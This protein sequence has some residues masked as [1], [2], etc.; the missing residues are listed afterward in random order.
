[1]IHDVI[2]IGAGPAGLTA[3]LYVLRANLKALIIEDPFIA[4]QAAYAFVIENFPGFPGG[5]SGMDLM[6]KLKEQ[7]ASFG[8]E[9]LS[10]SAAGITNSG[11]GPQL[12]QVSAG[13][14]VYGAVSVIVASGAIPKKLG[15][16]GEYEFTGKGVSYCA[17]CDGALFKDK[18]VVVAG[19]G[20]SALEE[21][22]FLSRFAKKVSIV[23][24]RDKLRAAKI[25][26]TKV[27]AQDKIGIMWNS[28]I[29]E[30]MGEKAVSK[31]RLRDTVTGELRD[32]DC[33]G[34]FVSVGTTPNTDFVKDTLDMDENGYII[35][36]NGL[37]ASAQGIFVCGDCRDTLF[38]QIV[39]A[40]GDGAVAARS[41]V[42]YVDTMKDC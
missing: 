39:T 13:K 11:Q 26:Q 32:I 2:V 19:G 42:H 18:N 17:A 15:V 36:G 6:K 38:R 25:L 1:L 27:F 7:V 34:L 23:H 21:A 28:A 22:L 5:I 29:E 30:I 12:W 24:R 33:Q 16:S 31:L 40:C 35:T 10:E 14:S 9:I 37:S 8:V 20:D 3:A 41:C 4:S